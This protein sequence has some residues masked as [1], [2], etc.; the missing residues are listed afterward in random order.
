MRASWDQTA[1]GYE[2][3]PPPPRRFPAACLLRREVLGRRMMH[4][5]RGRG[6]LGIQLVAA[7]EPHP[8]GL[9]RRQDAEEH[10][11]LLDVRTRGISPRVAQPALLPDA[12]LLADAAV[13]VLRRPLRRLHAEPMQVVAL[14]VVAPTGA[15]GDEVG[16]A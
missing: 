12:Q 16:R 11:V 8:D 13:D 7:G 10:L 3:N 2:W 5:Q 6:L 14:A 15:A 1:V 4:H 9:A